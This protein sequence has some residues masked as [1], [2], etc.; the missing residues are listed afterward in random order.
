MIY[1]YLLTLGLAS[2]FLLGCGKEAAEDTTTAQ[3]AGDAPSSSS[4]LVADG[5]TQAAEAV[6]AAKQQATQAVD[7]A[8]AKATEVADK[9]KEISSAQKDALIDKIKDATSEIDLS[10]LKPKLS[11]GLSQLTSGGGET[12]V[13]A[14]EKVKDANSNLQEQIAK[15]KAAT[16]DNWEDVQASAMSAI[17]RLK[18]AWADFQAAQGN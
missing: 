4:S 18:T 6:D 8:K 17:D 3:P 5:Q 15:V 9:V 13:K 14:V 7:A 1:R 12:Y 10:Q 2:L 11:G 16:P